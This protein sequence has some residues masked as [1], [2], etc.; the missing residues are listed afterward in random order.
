MKTEQKVF[1][2]KLT[3]IGFIYHEQDHFTKIGVE[4]RFK[5]GSIN[6]LTN[7]ASLFISRGDVLHFTI[8]NVDGKMWVDEII[9]VDKPPMQ[10][11]SFKE[12]QLKRLTESKM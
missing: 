4:F 1:R 10:K 3:G 2:G 7:K 8:K 6:Y 12:R 9:R 5:Q 11:V